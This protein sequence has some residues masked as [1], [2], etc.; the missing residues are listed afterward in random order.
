MQNFSIKIFVFRPATAPKEIPTATCD[1]THAT[2]PNFIVRKNLGNLNKMVDSFIPRDKQDNPVFIDCQQRLGS[3]QDETYT[4]WMSNAQRAREDKKKKRM[5][6]NMGERCK[7]AEDLIKGLT[8]G[9]GY[10]QY[11]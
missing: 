8:E 11:Q 9:P 5:I 2:I 7:I 10:Y 6:R 3:P 1:E 4:G